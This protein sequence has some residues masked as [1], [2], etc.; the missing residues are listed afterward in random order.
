MEEERLDRELI[1][2]LECVE[3]GLGRHYVAADVKYT[4]ANGEAS[5]DKVTFSVDIIPEL[6]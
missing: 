2:T 1:F 3:L 6:K 4:A 5:Q